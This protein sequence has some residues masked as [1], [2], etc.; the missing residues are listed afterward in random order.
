MTRSQQEG[1]SRQQMEGI[2]PEEPVPEVVMQGGTEESILAAL[3]QL[4]A[5]MM[6][7]KKERERDALELSALRRE[8]AGLREEI[9]THIPSQTTPFIQDQGES[10]ALQDKSR[11]VYQSATK[12]DRDDLVNRSP[13]IHRILEAKL[14]D[15]WRGLAID[16][17]DGTSDPGEHVDIFTTQVGLYTESDALWCRIFPTSLQGPALSWFTRLPPLSIDSFTTLTRRFNLQF[18][19]SRPHPLTSLAL[20]NIRQEKGESLRA[21]MERFGKVTLSIHN[22]ELAVV[23]HHLTTALKPGPFVNSLCKKPPINLDELR[24]R[25]AKYMQMEELSEYRSQVRMDQG[26][27]SKDIEGK[28]AFKARRGND[29]G[30]ELERPP[31]RPKYPSYT[32]LN[33]NQ[34]R[35][36]DQALAT[37]ILRMPRRANT[38]PRADKSKSCRYHQNRGHTTEECTALRDKIEELIKGGYLKDFVQTDPTKQSNRGRDRHPDSPKR[39]D[40]KKIERHRTTGAGPESPQLE[41]LKKSTRKGRIRIPPITFTDDDF[42][43]VDPVQDDP[44]VISVDILNCTVRKTLIDQG[45]SADILYRNTFK[46]LGIAEQELKEYHEPLVGFS[47]ERVETKGCIDL[48]TTF[49]SEHEGKSIRV[50]YL[51]VHTN[52]SYNILLGRPSLNKLKAIVSTPHLDMKFLSER[53]RIVTVHADQKTARE[54]Y[55]A[56][57][58]LKPFHGNNRDVNIVSP[59]LEEELDVELDPRMDAEYRVE[60]NENKQSF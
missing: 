4:K 39:F 1:T 42:Q 8:N 20:V 49:G 52:T 18:A 47:G 14:P 34:A 12:D 45:S 11:Q 26:S 37:E 27:N 54:C 36:L 44:M 46:Q 50:T 40:H 19:T 24:S 29:R 30:N 22:L 9:R 25:A 33:T 10:S 3:R 60:P 43:E 57:L 28:E 48:Y 7:M 17:Y 13:F 55:F 35:I 59:W 2:T 32:T 31:R 53:G 38:P 41:D 56:S 58:R 51:V 16:K 5:E 6:E 23:M 15:N 21:F